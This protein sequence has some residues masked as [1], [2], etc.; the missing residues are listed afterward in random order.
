MVEISENFPGKEIS[1]ICHCGTTETMS[2]I[3]Y[4]EKWNNGIQPSLKYEK[5]FTGRIS[6][7]IMIFEKFEENFGKREKMN[8]TMNEKQ[9]PPCDPCDPLSCTVDS[10]G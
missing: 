2:H 7:Q 6:D 8:E 10:N 1:S 9:K 3:Y 5:I 4:C